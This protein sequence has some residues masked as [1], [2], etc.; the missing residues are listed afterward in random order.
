MSS[1]FICHLKKVG[2]EEFARG[3]HF[4]GEDNT[5][6]GAN[7]SVVGE[8]LSLEAASEANANMLVAGREGFAPVV[9]RSVLCLLACRAS[10]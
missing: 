6:E 10:R 7:K 2:G 1:A 4:A 9:V 3:E 8:T 5:L